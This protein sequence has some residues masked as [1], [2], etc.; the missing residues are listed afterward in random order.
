MS[1][2]DSKEFRDAL[3]AFA[4]GVTVVTATDRRG[5]PIAMTANSFSS[6]SLEPPLV[7]WS[8]NRTHDIAD[9]FIEA[10]HYAVHVLTQDQESFSNHFA[11]ERTDKFEGIAYDTGTNGLPLLR[12]CSARFQCRVEQR[13]DGGDHVI[14]LGR[15]IEMDYT[16][17][18]PLIF[19]A[20]KYRRLT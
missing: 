16:T 9:D 10:D 20:G 3:G 7:L 6:V 14:L 12:A 18:N 8:V 1:T 11:G 17:E 2:I 15:V 4:T 5:A 19:H 13:Y